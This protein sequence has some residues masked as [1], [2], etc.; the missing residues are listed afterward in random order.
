MGNIRVEKRNSTYIPVDEFT[1]VLP[2]DMRDS[3]FIDRIHGIVPGWEL[4]KISRS[5]IHLSKG[6]GIASDYFC[7]ILHNLRKEHYG[8]KISENI[9]IS[10]NF[11]IRD[12][13]A[14]KKILSGMI[15]ILVPH[16]SLDSNEVK[17]LSDIAIEYRQQVSDWLHI[18][19]PGEYPKKRLT[20]ILRS[21]GP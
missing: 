16:G 14:V 1:Y 12:E 9:E 10:D 17:I 11:T 2:P 4:P 18:L 3:A 5:G 8:Y 20:Y 15:K 19:D 13:K 7:E 6:Y 21:T